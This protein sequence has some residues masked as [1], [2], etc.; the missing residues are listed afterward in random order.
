MSGSITFEKR[1]RAAAQ[2][3]DFTRLRETAAGADLAAISMLSA[4]S[5][6]PTFVY[7]VAQGPEAVRISDMGRLAKGAIGGQGSTPCPH[8]RT[9]ARGTR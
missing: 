9:D 7:L 4:G 2:E 1:Q 3:S 5:R 6:K 8:P